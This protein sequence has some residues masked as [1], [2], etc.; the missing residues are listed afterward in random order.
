MSTSSTHDSTVNSFYLAF[1]GRPAD[2][3]GLK[4]WSTQLAAN[5]GDMGA[6]VNFFADSEE[7]QVRFGTDTTADRIAEIYSQLFNRAPD[8]DG[9][10]FWTNAID[11]GHATL[12]D[13]ALSIF[14]GAQGADA[15]LSQLRQQAADAFTAQVEAGGSQYAGYA[16]IEAARVLVR[17]V[18]L[19][20]TQDDLDVLVKSAVSFADTATKTPQV[21]DA[22]AVNTTL[23]ALFDTARGLKEPVALAKALADTATAAAGDPVTLESLLRGGGMDKVLKVMPT[24]ATLQDVVDALGTG[25]LPA[26]VEV[27]YPTAPTAPGTPSAPTFKLSF[28]H[29][30]ESALDAKHDNLTNVEVADVTFKYSGA[31]STAVQRFVASTDGKHWDEVTVSTDA[32]TKTVVAKGVDLTGGLSHGMAQ[33]FFTIQATAPQ[34]VTTTIELRAL[35]ANDK[36]IGSII[37]DIVFDGYV[38]RPYVT[39]ANPVSQNGHFIPTSYV[40]TGNATF[41]VEGIEKGAKVEYAMAKP[42]PVIYAE[43]QISTPVP[44]WSEVKP[45]LKAG[46]NYVQVRQTDLAGNQSSSMVQVLL[47]LDGPVGKPSIALVEDDG[48]SK[49]DGITSVAKL[50]ITN[51]DLH[52]DTGWEYST[53]NG[54]TWTFGKLNNGTGTAELDL[55]KMGKDAVNLQVRQLDAAGNVSK[56]SEALTFT[57]VPAV[58]DVEPTFHVGGLGGAIGISGTATDAVIVDLTN[59]TIAREG[60]PDSVEPV[61]ITSVNAVNYAGSVTVAGTVAEIAAVA[62]NFEKNGIAGYGLVDAKSSIFTGV[63]G[64]RAFVSEVIGLLAGAKFIKLTDTLSLEERALFDGLANFDD[65]ALDALVD[66]MIPGAPVV[67]LEVDSGKFIF[68]DRDGVTNIGAYKVIGVEVGAAVQFSKDGQ[69]NWTTVKPVAEEG[70]NSFFVRQVDQAG[71]VGADVKFAFTLDTKAPAMPTVSLVEDTGIDGDLITT[72]A[73]VRFSGLEPYS[74]IEYRTSA[75][76]EWLSLNWADDKGSDVLLPI[77]GEGNHYIEV[78]QFDQAGNESKAASL[79]FKIDPNAPTAPVQDPVLP[80]M[81]TFSVEMVEE[82]LELTS[83]TDGEVFID[84]MQYFIYPDLGEGTNFMAA[85][86]AIIGAQNEIIEGPVGI[87]SS[88]GPL[89]YDST[90][91]TYVFGTNEGE[92]FM[93]QNV[94]GFGGADALE[95]T[96]GADHLFGGDGDDY[97]GASFGNDYVVGGRGGDQIDLGIDGNI[98]TVVIG[99]GDTGVDLF[100]EEDRI[101]T[102]SIDQIQNFRLDDVIVVGDV[103]TKDPVLQTTFLTDPTANHYAV[104]RGYAYG[105]SFS[106]DNVSNSYLLQWAD[107]E[108]VNTILLQNLEQAPAFAIDVDSGTMTLIEVVGVSDPGPGIPG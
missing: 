16:S 72:T 61:D 85:G 99:R 48:D 68:G 97:I 75:E 41:T 90:N 15:T 82:G 22:I 7:A 5:N 57:I 42:V 37:Q 78:R 43:T 107:G 55:S 47:D 63:P 24:K 59:N 27:V 93:G 32:A 86:K 10:A 29:V 71:N 87:N 12:A 38:Q 39:F 53:D 67:E 96:A 20:A 45:E 23:L 9:M 73:T 98:D 77:Q 50:A 35:D 100:L 33:S 80:P 18:T 40:A 60:Y 2:P 19:D 14:N 103:F 70:E 79:E 108:H 13:V 81:P 64:D 49:S 1:Y 65:K 30:D 34:N 66:D 26:A 21:V 28:D 31:S 104:V 101:S 91:R 94:W 105:G 11:K 92:E 106:V 69:T 44:D 36:V 89:L 62:A 54:A 3:A 95:G 58:E 25:G 76:G 17:A 56:A 6:I 102:M 74:L 51:L 8:A 46:W 83:N 88:L 52:L 4:F 84:A